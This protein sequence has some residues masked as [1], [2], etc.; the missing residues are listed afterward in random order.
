MAEKMKTSKL[1]SDVNIL[2]ILLENVTV[3]FSN[4]GSEFEVVASEPITIDGHCDNSTGN[5]KV[6]NTNSKNTVNVTLKFPSNA[7][8]EEVNITAT[9]NVKFQQSYFNTKKFNIN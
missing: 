1:G 9:N 2:N 6:L 7:K 4:E 8:Y 3:L 5:V